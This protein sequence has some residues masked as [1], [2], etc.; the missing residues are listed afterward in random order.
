MKVALEPFGGARPAGVE[1][2]DV[3]VERKSGQ[4][5]LTYTLTADLAQIALPAASAPERKDE[6]WKHTCFEAFLAGPNGYREFN[7]S[8][9]GAWAA[10]DFSAPRQGM[11]NAAISA[12]AME[13]NTLEHGVQLLASLPV[14]SEFVRMGLSAVIEKPDGSKSYWALKHPAAK[15]D[16]HHPDAFTLQL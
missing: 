8:P 3:A 12:P 5:H 14:P 4:L 11:R 10:Y 16:F 13:L 2:I 1:G 6:L 7:F 15:P 9:S